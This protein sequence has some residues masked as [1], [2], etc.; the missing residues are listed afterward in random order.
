[1]NQ[2]TL[3]LRMKQSEGVLVRLL[4]VIR[5]RRY[6]ILSLTAIPSED[7]SSFDIQATIE[8]D[9]AA[10]VL[11][12]QIEKLVDVSEVEVI[13]SDEAGQDARAAGSGN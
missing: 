5:K 10:S 1:V 8:A 4:S 12:R 7:G 3:Q 11:V 2:F 13:E 6:E 9:R